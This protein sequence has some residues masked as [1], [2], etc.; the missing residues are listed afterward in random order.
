[1]EDGGEERYKIDFVQ[2]ERKG[3]VKEENKRETHRRRRKQKI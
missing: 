3:K 2:G 1:M